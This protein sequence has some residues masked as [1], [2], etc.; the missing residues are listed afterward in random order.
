VVCRYVNA[1]FSGIDYKARRSGDR[2]TQEIEK[3]IK[4]SYESVVLLELYSYSD[5]VITIHVLE[6]DGSLVCSIF[7]AVTLALM[8]A[9]ISMKD[10]IVACSSG[11]VRHS[12]CCDLIQLEQSAGGAYLPVAIL[13]KSNDIIYTQLESR[14]SVDNLESALELAVLGCAEIRRIIEAGIKGSIEHALERGSV[15]T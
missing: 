14:L 10:M 15:P 2:R 13:S 3:I 6:N 8:D 5:I 11:Y 9:G 1:P 12:L 4:D 7:N